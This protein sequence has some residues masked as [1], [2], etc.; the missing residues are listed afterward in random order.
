M[1]D[2]SDDPSPPRVYGG[3]SAQER[4][5]DR[6][7]RLLA[8]ALD[9]FGTDGFPSTTIERLC[10]VAN[11]ATRSFY[12]EFASREDLLRTVY[13]ELV[14]A[15]TARIVGALEEQDG[16]LD[17]RVRRAVGAYLGYV[18]GG[19]AAGPRRAPRGPGGPGAAGAPPRGRHGFAR[20]IQRELLGPTP[21]VDEWRRRV[22]S[23]ALAGAVSEVL[24][25]WS[26]LPDPRPD[27]AVVHAEMTNLYVAA[28][29]PLRDGPP[30]QE[31]AGDA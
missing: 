3:R 19:P 9:L 1:A 14:V 13:D 8:A 16:T 22:V 26:G 6:R 12:E 15:A 17:E 4:R 24:V 23:L 2:P 31:R 21:S 28:L 10:A 11:I 30:G 29:A 20:L 25:D 18:E 7:A 27:L 5:Q